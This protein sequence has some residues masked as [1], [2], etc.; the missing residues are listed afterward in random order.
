MIPRIT[1][2]AKPRTVSS[3]VTAICSHSGPWAVP[4]STHV[5]SWVQIPEGCPKKNGSTAQVPLSGP[6]QPSRVVSSQL[7]TMKIERATRRTSTSTRRRS[8]ALALAA[9]KSSV[10]A[11]VAA[12]GLRRDAVL[13]ALIADEHLI[14]EVVPD[15]PVELDQPRLEA[16]LRDVPRPWE[17]DAVASLDRAWSRGDH[18]DPVGHADRLLE[19]VR[20]EH[21]R[22]AGRCPKV[23]QLVLHDS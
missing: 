9:S 17:V 2:I 6:W 11:S 19:V 21:D 23:E 20:H 10:A 14:P 15:L 1:P 4:F 7:P 16:D 5:T 8:R 12:T 3:R 18:D 13:R 22:G